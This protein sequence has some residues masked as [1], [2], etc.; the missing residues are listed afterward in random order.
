MAG[1]ASLH[2]IARP[3]RP[4]G[5]RTPVI[6]RPPCGIMRLMGTAPTPPPAPLPGVIAQ[7]PLL[8][9]AAR[10]A[11]AGALALGAPAAAAEPA[12]RAAPPLA[13]APAAG[14]LTVV[15]F[16]SHDCPICTGSMPEVQRIAD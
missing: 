15:L 12:E 8:L 14:A 10:L 16:A 3:L 6:P 1:P 4:P 13:S 7:L 9:L 2:E 11:L 5:R